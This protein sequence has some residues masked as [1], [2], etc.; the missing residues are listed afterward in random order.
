MEKK[1]LYKKIKDEI[2]KTKKEFDN[3][4]SI[5][6]YVSINKD[7][8]YKEFSPYKNDLNDGI[9]TYI[10]EKY[11]FDFSDKDL[12]IIFVGIE[13]QF[14]DEDKE[15]IINA[16]KEHYF[17]EAKSETFEI[18]KT[19]LVSIVLLIIGIILLGL[20]A[21]FSLSLK[22]ELSEIISIFAWVFVWEACDLMTFTNMNHRKNRLKYSK[23]YDATYSFKEDDDGYLS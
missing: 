12:N 13:N 21:F 7:N 6:V 15:R 1:E 4:S 8:V 10:E 19:T 20:Y 22:Y 9:Y 23:I 18:R 14:S 2:K 5:D 3:K 16:S 17:N 11:R